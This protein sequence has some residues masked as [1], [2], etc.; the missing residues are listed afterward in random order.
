MGVQQ[1][2]LCQILCKNSLLIVVIKVTLACALIR[3]ANFLLDIR[4]LTKFKNQTDSKFE[5]VGEIY[6]LR[7]M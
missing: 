2:L 7:C 3:L 5:L 6:T 1:F 4:Y